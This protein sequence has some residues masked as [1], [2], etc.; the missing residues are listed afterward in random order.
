MGHFEAAA[1]SSIASPS[2]TLF[3]Q[4]TTMIMLAVCTAILGARTPASQSPI[5][6]EAKFDAEGLH[7][8]LAPVR[9]GGS[10][11]WCSIDSGGS[12]VLSLDTTKARRAGL[13]P[14]ATGSSAGIGPAA[15]QDQRVRGVAVDIGGVKLPDSTIILRDQPSIVPDI[16]CV[17]GL[18]LLQDYVVEFDYETPRLRILDG[19]GFRPGADGVV[20]PFD[21][22]RFRNPYIEAGLSLADGKEVRPHL[23]LDTG[24][25]TYSAVLMKPFI[26]ANSILMR[27]GRVVAE[28]SHTS[29][30]KLSSA[31]IL[32]L[33]LGSAAIADPVIGL[34]LSNAAGVIEDGMVGAGFFRRFTVTFDYTRRQVW[35]NP[36]RHLK[37][38][39]PFDASGLVLAYNANQEYVIDGVAPNSAGEA[40][41]VQVGD[42]VVSI[43]GR[44]WRNLTLGDIRALLS[45]PNETRQLRLDRHGQS[46]DATV[47]L[48]DRLGPLAN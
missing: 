45:R 35:L 15:V 20:I 10:T 19:R 44:D 32:E 3:Q 5:V 34:V 48:K 18:G 37:E 14:N 25:S 39:Q 22:D 41:N 47:S 6:V 38:R 4:I 24:A 33:R 30:L 27:A 29:G 46:I 42:R 7:Q 16:D 12:W 11:F 26:D 31:R 43:D 2:R 21:L 13:R 8:F 23:I 9:I 28:T 36:N 17:F 40:A 1:M